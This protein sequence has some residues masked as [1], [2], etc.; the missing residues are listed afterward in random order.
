VDP[1]QLKKIQ[2][3]NYFYTNPDGYEKNISVDELQKMGPSDQKEVMILW[4]NERYTDPCHTQPYCTEEGGYLFIDGGP[5]YAQEVLEEEFYT[6]VDDEVLNDVIDELGSSYTQWTHTA[7]FSANDYY[8]P[9]E[10]YDVDAALEDKGALD[11]LYN[12]LNSMRSLLK[13][14][15]LMDAKLHRFQLMMIYGFCITSLESYLSDVFARQIF[16]DDCLKEKYLN[17]EKSLK[18]QKFSLGDLYK[19]HKTIDAVIK[20]K[21]AST[22][23]HALE[24]VKGLYKNVLNVDIGDISDLVVSINKRHDF[25]HRGGKDIDGNEV[26]TSKQEVE[27]LINRVENLCRDLESKIDDLLPF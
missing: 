7:A 20:K 11:G 26:T 27:E 21:I 25:I 23:F 10:Y 12:N 8:D 19:K 14:K 22:S 1:D 5:F 4:F 3:D 18:E 15:D 17:A 24:K 2:K 9:M 6:A 16:S 13:E